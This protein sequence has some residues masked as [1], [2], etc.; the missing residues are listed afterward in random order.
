M[1]GDSTHD[2]ALTPKEIQSIKS[3]N[4]IAAGYKHALALTRTH[5]MFKVLCLFEL[6]WLIFF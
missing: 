6:L 5:F 2:N 1:L 3:V 4:R